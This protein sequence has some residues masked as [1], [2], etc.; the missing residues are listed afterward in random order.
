MNPCVG[1]DVAKLHH[2]LTIGPM[3]Q[4]TRYSN[5]APGIRKIV[6]ALRRQPHGTIVIESTGG[7]E[8]RLVDALTQEGLPVV[9][10]NPWQVR[11]FAQGLGELAKT[12]LIDARILAL[13]GER[14]DIQVRP[15]PS[16]RQRQMAELT[17]RRRQ[18]MG[19]V[20]AEKNRRENAS[21]AM[22]RDIERHLRFL[23][24]EVAK[25]DKKIDDAIAQDAEQAEHLE[26]LQTVPSIGPVVARTVLIDL[27]EIGTLNRRQ[28]AKL[29]GLAPFANDSGKKRGQ[30]HIR[31][32]RVAPRTAL[33]LAAMNAA[34]FNPVFQPMYQR[35]IEA[36]K[37]PKVAF[38]AIARKLLTILNAMV[39]DQTTWQE[40]MYSIGS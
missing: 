27:P 17:R 2:D 29:A 35:M 26:R 6:L 16:K 30:R 19:D 22:C 31:A 3:G 38:V 12:D 25:L 15:L 36:G 18:L 33:Y 23:E 39:R 5:T 8:R 11:R 32:G 24:R 7:Y 14:T 4:V 28:V 10:V 21:T 37:P 1:I 13:F 9:V 40:N 34:R 20:A